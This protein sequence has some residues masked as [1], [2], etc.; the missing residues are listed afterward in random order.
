MFT[1][2]IHRIAG[3]AS[4]SSH[5]CLDPN[6]TFKE[7]L[8]YCLVTTLTAL[9]TRV[10]DDPIMLRPSLRAGW[11]CGW[12]GYRGSLVISR[13]FRQAAIEVRGSDLQSL[14]RQL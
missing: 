12:R 10:T 2:Q 6:A 3:L 5:P 9:Q 13:M 8:V 4:Y 1:I 7:R 14:E 11:M